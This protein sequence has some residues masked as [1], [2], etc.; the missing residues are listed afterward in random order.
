[1]ETSSSSSSSSSSEPVPEL[2]ADLRLCIISLLPL[3]DLALSGRLACKDAAQ[4]FS[5]PPQRTAC[6]SQPLPAHAATA[7][8][9]VEGAQAALRKLP[10]VRKLLLIIWAAASGCEAN[11]EFAWELLQPHVFPELL[12]TEHIL[13]LLSDQFYKTNS[14]VQPE[15]AYA[16]LAT[17]AAHLLPSLEQRCPG[18]VSAAVTLGAAAEHSDL[19]GLQA[20]WGLLW[21]RVRSSHEPRGDEIGDG[22]THEEVWDQNLRATLVYLLMTA[23]CS[24]TPDALAKMEW[25]AE[26]GRLFANGRILD[27]DDP[28]VTTLCRAA[29]SSGDLARLQWLAEHGFPWRTLKAAR[30][31]LEHAN[32]T[33][34]RR[35]D[36]ARCYLPPASSPIWRRSKC[37]C[38]AAALRKD[39]VAKLRWLAD[40]GATL[41]DPKPLKAAAKYGN[42]ETVQYLVAHRRAQRN[43]REQEEDALPPDAGLL[44]HALGAA[45]ASGSVPTASWLHQQGGQLQA[46]SFLTAARQ[47]DVPMVR[48]LLEAG[49]PRGANTLGS[50]A[51]E[52]PIGCAADG[53]RLLEAVRLLAAAGWP[54]AREGEEEGGEHPVAPAGQEHSVWRGVWGLLPAGERQVLR[55][56]ARKATVAGCQ[57]TLEALAGVGVFKAVGAEEAAALYTT[58]AQQGDRSTLECLR[59]LGVPL[60]EGVLLTAA[61]SYDTQLPVLRWLEQ[62]GASIGPAA[63]R[64]LLSA[65]EDGTHNPGLRVHERAELAAWL[66]GLGGAAAVGA[67]AEAG[68]GGVVND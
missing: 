25:M 20:A 52:W 68:S 59:R 62:Q 40:R 55:E 29:I 14:C 64:E 63:I 8:W 41:E 44:S 19:A 18:L 16:A 33:F 34:L 49:C 31:A 67:G 30:A 24:T 11:V 4:H 46:E 65:V 50:V 21:Q 37:A 56:A 47:G 45:V 2:S 51:A 58:A 17:G 39:S 27:D 3:N 66:R 12:Q 42:L 35:M 13:C 5:Q 43:R 48:W 60:C 15:K 10:F 54:A 28:G 9:C 36:E 22:D 7:P 53:E 6:P 1:M 26:A 32:L 23:A 57:P 61:V 38:S